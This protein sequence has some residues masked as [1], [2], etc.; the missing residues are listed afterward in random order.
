MIMVVAASRASMGGYI[1]S[2]SIKKI[3]KWASHEICKVPATIAYVF[4]A[5]FGFQVL[6][7]IIKVKK[8]DERERLVTRTT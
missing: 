3:N 4:C 2:Q 1:S 7:G 5:F 6:F 8:L